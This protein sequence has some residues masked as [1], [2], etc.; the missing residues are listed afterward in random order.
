MNDRKEGFVLIFAMLFILVI[1][2]IAVSYLGIASNEV[3]LSRRSADNVQAYYAAEAGVARMLILLKE[4]T[5]LRNTNGTINLAA[6]DS[7]TFNVV[8]TLLGTT[9]PAFRIT[10]TGTYNGIVKI[11]NFSIRGRPASFF[12]MFNNTDDRGNT[13]VYHITGDTITGP[14][15]VNDR[16]NIAGSPQF[17]GPVSST[18]ATINYYNGGPPR[19]NPLFAVSLNLGAPAIAFPTVANTVTPLRALAQGGGLYLEG[20]SGVTLRQNGTMDVVNGARNRANG[21]PNDFAENMLIPAN[22]VLFVNNGD[23]NISGIM[24]GQLTAATNRNINIVGDTFYNN[25]PVTDPA[26]T[27]ILGLIAERDISVARSAPFNVNIDACILAL[28]SFGAEVWNSQLR[29]TLNIYG[30]IA[31]DVRGIIGQFNNSGRVSGYT[32]NY[33]YDQR[34]NSSMPPFFPMLRDIIGWSYIK[35][36]WNES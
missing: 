13:H 32:K 12:A 25:D 19:D 22:G 23:L 16:M 5:S 8:V 31:Q 28:G 1:F 9:P 20:N 21:Q 11:I 4:D 10:S 35:V 34:L 30:S 29:G 2:V 36:S 26:S 3:Q 18:A 33:I 14:Y 27:D 17:L 7:A 15:H 24:N 6:G